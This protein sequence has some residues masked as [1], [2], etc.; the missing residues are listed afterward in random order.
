MKEAGAGTPEKELCRKYGIC[1]QTCYRWM[2]ELAVW[3]WL[4]RG[5]APIVNDKS[6]KSICKLN[7]QEHKR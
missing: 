4:K 2:S 3:R 6:L 5:D 1:E 7:K